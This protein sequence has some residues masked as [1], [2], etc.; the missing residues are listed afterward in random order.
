MSPASSPDTARVLVLFVHPALEKS[1]VNRFLLEAARK[2]DG[3]TCHDLYEA[4]PDFHVDVQAEQELLAGHDVIVMQHPFYWYS[5]PALL[6]EWLDLV[7][8]HGWAYG[9]TGQALH[10]KT[11]LNAITTG[12][13]ERAYCAAGYNHFTLLELLAPFAQ[14]AALCGMDYLP[15]FAVHGPLNMPPEAVATHA[16][17]Y[18]KLLAACVAGTLDREAARGLPRLNATLDRVLAG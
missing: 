4:Y 14:T 6:K 3:V 2:V 5:S 7:L 1:R 11:L 12:G 13:P 8:E 15:P 18:A 17:D 10:G 9:S 16:A